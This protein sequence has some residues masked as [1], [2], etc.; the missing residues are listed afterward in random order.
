[1]RK[2]ST[3]FQGSS[4]V[5]SYGTHLISPAVN[6]DNTCE[7]LSTKKAHKSLS[8]QGF[9]WGWTRRCSLPSTYQ[10]SRL[11]EGKQVCSTNHIVCRNILGT[12]IHSYHLGNYGNPPEIKFQ[13]PGKCQHCKQTFLRM[14]ASSLLCNSFLY[15][16]LL[17]EWF[18]VDQELTQK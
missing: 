7:M 1:M 12:V 11:L 5:K 9:Y 8:V 6:C 17:I 15:T 10:N 13:V 18:Q 4:P 3:I 2:P 16:L 14:A